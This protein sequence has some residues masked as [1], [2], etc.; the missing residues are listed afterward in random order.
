MTLLESCLEEVR[1]DILYWNKQK[2]WEQKKK[3]V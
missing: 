3:L 1:P 2:A